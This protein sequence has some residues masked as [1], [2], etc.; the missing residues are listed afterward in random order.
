MENHLDPLGRPHPV[1]LHQAVLADDLAEV[2]RLLAQ[3]ADPNQPDSLQP[4]PNLK[5]IAHYGGKEQ[6]ADQPLGHTPLLLAARYGH[7]RLIAPL[8]QHGAD[9]N[10]R[11]FLDETPLHWAAENGHLQTLETLLEGGAQ[12]ERP[13]LMAALAHNHPRC[14]Q[15]LLQ[16]GLAP[17]QKTLLEAAYLADADLLRQILALKPRLKLG[18]ALAPIIHAS[19]LLPAD[20]SPPGRWTTIWNEHGCFHRVPQPQEKIL[21]ALEVLLQA[22]A[23]LHENTPL[24]SALE[25]AERQNLPL[26][27]Q[28]LQLAG[29]QPQPAPT[30]P[31]PKPPR[32][33]KPLDQPTFTKLPDLSQLAQTLGCISTQPAYLRG[34]HEYALNQPIDL[35]TLQN[36]W[37]QQG[38]YLYHP[39]PPEKLAAI[40]A[41]HWSTAIALM[42]T[43]GANHDLGPGDLLQWLKTLEQD[44]PFQLTTITHDRL[45]GTF[46]SPI[47]N[48]KQMAKRMHKI[49]PDLVDQGCGTLALLAQ[50]LQ[51]HPTRLYLWWD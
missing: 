10:Q 11:D 38:I 50:E 49:C 6:I 7:H 30:P 18:K 44:Q 33:P 5:Q 17:D 51:T 37:I 42:Q 32:Q 45:E 26:I 13:A 15:R 25:A 19:R 46:L 31:A 43:N 21:E 16:A 4:A 41:N 47:A 23:P 36:H 24:G 3:G 14:A 12:P 28:R 34:G 8:L 2:T 48:P 9:P 35:P 1:N 39:G 20:Q 27:T 29:A 40:P 22:G